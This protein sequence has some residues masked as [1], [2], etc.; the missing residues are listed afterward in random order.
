MRELNTKIDYHSVY[1]RELELGE[2]SYF[3]NN[4]SI[5][6]QH[7]ISFDIPDEFRNAQCIYS[8]PAWHYGYDEFRKRAGLDESSYD[9][10]LSNILRI[11]YELNIP[12]FIVMGK[13]MAK[14]LRPE[15]LGDVYL[16]SYKSIQGCWNCEPINCSN[17][18]DLA[19][20]VAN[21]FDNILDFSCGYGIIARELY[22]KNKKFICS[23]INK[24]CVYYIANNFMGYEPWKY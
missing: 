22:K 20:K 15:K 14:K 4:G 2:L 16:H 21:R 9:F 3:D 8:E 10:Y 13:R 5:A 19:S 1:F 17:N 6:M 24:K 12:S 7:D 18:F 23:D 11:I